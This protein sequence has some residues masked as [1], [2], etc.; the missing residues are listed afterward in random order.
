LGYGIH[1]SRKGEKNK[2]IQNQI[3][4]LMK[5]KILGLIF[6]TF[7]TVLLAQDSLLVFDY[8]VKYEGKMG[9]EKPDFTETFLVNSQDSTYYGIMK[10]TAVG[11]SLFVSMSDQKYLLEFLPKLPDPVEDSLIFRSNQVRVRKIGKP[12]KLHPME[13]LIE[14]DTVMNGNNYQMRVVGPKLKKLPK[15]SLVG[16]FKYIYEAQDTIYQKIPTRFLWLQETFET[17]P[18]IPNGILYYAE[19]DRGP[20]QKRTRT[21]KGIMPTRL[22]IIFE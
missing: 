16:F 22:K 5:H 2:N 8:A 21:L 4:I 1:I 19:E 15:N 10:E 13:I 9:L 14:E 3:F 12:E 6:F 11:I 7:S 18:H 17:K 20:E